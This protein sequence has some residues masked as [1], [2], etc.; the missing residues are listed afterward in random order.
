MKLLNTNTTI[1]FVGL[2][3]MGNAMAKNLLKA[4]YSLKVFNR[5]LEKTREVVEAGAVLADSVAETA[6][7][8]DALITIVGT[9]DDVREIYLSEN[10]IIANAAK[11]TILID[12]TTSEPSLAK[13]IAES[14]KMKNLIALD[15]PVSGGDIGAKNGSLSIMIGGDE[16]AFLAAKPLFEILGKTVVLQGNSGSGQHTKMCNQ[17][18]I[19]TNMIGIME[20]LVYAKKSGL[21]PDVVL[22]SIGSGAAASWSLNNLQPRVINNDYEP[23]FYVSHF[24]KDMGIALKES[25]KMNIE[26]PGLTLAYSLYEKL[27]ASGKGSLGTQALYKL[28]DDMK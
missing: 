5:S 16:N 10:G 23:G 9:P 6:N 22:Q 3:V 25:G 24:L 13:E 27:V 7:D 18:A 4:G 21:N 26:M 1:G 15:A 20:A 8:V 11:Q 2:G 28:W 14:A 12:M 19:A 17:I